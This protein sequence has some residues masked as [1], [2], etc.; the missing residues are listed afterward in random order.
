[1]SA[2]DTQKASEIAYLEISALA[3]A[4]KADEGT[5]SSKLNTLWIEQDGEQIGA[6]S[7]PCTIP[8]FARENTNFRFIPG[9]ML[10][11]VYSYRN[12]YEMLKPK[13]V[14][15]DLAAETTKTVPV[16]TTTFEYNGAYSLDVLEDFDGVGLN[17]AATLKSDTTLVLVDDQ[18]EA[19]QFPGETPNKSGKYVLPPSTRGEFKTLQAFELPKFGTNVWMELNY[20]TN[21]NLTVGIFANEPLQSVQSPVVT[22][23]PNEE[24]NKVYINLVTEVSGFPNAI[25]YNIFFGSINTS[26]DT[27]TV[28]IDNIKLLY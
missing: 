5:A 24:W 27:A 15:W 28:W 9:I 21:V 13:Q 2:C 25:D 4:P 11:G 16:S 6:F 22:L 3:V 12:Q 26:S 20:K 1:L 17:F 19:F 8:V 18:T 7:P 23:F 14:T 10:N